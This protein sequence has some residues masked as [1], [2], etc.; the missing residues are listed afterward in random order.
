MTKEDLNVPN[1]FRVG[2]V[3][4]EEKITVS[5]KS[6]GVWMLEIP[7]MT[8]DTTCIIEVGD[9]GNKRRIISFCVAKF[10]F[11]ENN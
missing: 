5:K 8:A 3:I 6:L 1:I 9:E 11:R 4:T 10:I 2:N 7:P